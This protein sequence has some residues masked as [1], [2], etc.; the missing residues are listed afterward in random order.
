MNQG[1]ILSS[2]ITP[3]DSFG[4]AIAGDVVYVAD[5]TSGM[6]MIDVSNPMSPGIIGFLDTPDVAFGIAV[7]GTEVYVVDG[8]S[9]LLVIDVTC[10][11]A[12]CPADFTGQSNVPDSVVN[13]FDLLGLLAAW[14]PCE[15]PLPPG[16]SAR[17][18]SR[19]GRGTPR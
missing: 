2:V 10:S 15:A 1:V 18:T 13:V 11:A 9:G 12:T 19:R 17:S 16:D 6:L 4:I 5:N 14:G 3:P 7:L 8:D